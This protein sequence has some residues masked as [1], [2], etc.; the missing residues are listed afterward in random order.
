[1]LLV[2][3][4]DCSKRP[5]INI[6]YHNQTLLSTFNLCLVVG[7]MSAHKFI[8]ELL[9]YQNLPWPALIKHKITAIKFAFS[10]NIGI[11]QYN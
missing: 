3:L 6:L 10:C 4:F 5:Y 1:L 8:T 9:N 2:A 11:L 7:F